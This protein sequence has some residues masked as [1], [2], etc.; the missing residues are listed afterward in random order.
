MCIRD[1]NAAFATPQISVRLDRLSEEQKEV[2]KF[3]IKFCKENMELLQQSQIMPTE[4]GHL[5]PV[6]RTELRGE[7]IIAVYGPDRVISLNEDL[8][9]HTI[10]W[11]NKSPVAYVLMKQKNARN[12]CRYDCRGHVLE[13]VE[14]K[15]G[16]CRAVP[17]TA[18]GLLVISEQ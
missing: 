14:E 3:W 6:V 13:N 8:R 17:M 5:Y 18:G 2:L 15:K 16:G 12:I 1:R 10:I 4:A 11:A 9:K 7:E